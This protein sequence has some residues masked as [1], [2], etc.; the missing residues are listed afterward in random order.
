MASWRGYEIRPHE[1]GKENIVSNEFGVASEQAIT[2]MEMLD[3]VN[4]N[5]A[6]VI[7]SCQISLARSFSKLKVGSSHERLS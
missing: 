4:K 1:V 2:P 5:G 3:P 6:G 7:I